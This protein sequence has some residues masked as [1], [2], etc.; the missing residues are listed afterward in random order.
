M[1]LKVGRRDPIRGDCAI[2]HRI[3]G[4]HKV[5]RLDGETRLEGIATYFRFE[6][7]SIAVLE[8]DGETRLEGIATSMNDSLGLPVE[9]MLDGETRLEGIATF[10][11]SL[12]PKL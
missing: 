6:I 2:A 3:A 4:K 7:R 5:A 9:S 10:H 1:P 11:D 8:L 12:R